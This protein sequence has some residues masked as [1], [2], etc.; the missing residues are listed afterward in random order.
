MT[1][2]K[3]WLLYRNTWNHLTV[4]KKRA[5]AH[6]QMISTKCVYGSYIYIYLIYMYKQ[7]LALNNLQW[8][9]CHKTNNLCFHVC[10]SFEYVQNFFFFNCLFVCL[11]WIP[12]R[13]KFCE[14]QNWYFGLAVKY[15]GSVPFYSRRFNFQQGIAGLKPTRFW[16]QN[17]EKVIL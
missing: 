17:R 15:I 11:S 14:N 10:L 3:L 9:I 16:H 8:L 1:D 13:I 5:Q 6:L 12:L 7:D 2:V 4:C